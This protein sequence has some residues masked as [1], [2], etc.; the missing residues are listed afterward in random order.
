MPLRPLSSHNLNLG[1]FCVNQ[2]IQWLIIIIIDFQVQTMS[3]RTKCN[4]P[5][6]VWTCSVYTLGTLQKHFHWHAGSVYDCTLCGQKL[7]GKDKWTEH[8]QKLHPEN[9]EQVDTSQPNVKR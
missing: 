3:V 2:V 5:L 6:L 9:K 1:I 4:L 8:L 7:F